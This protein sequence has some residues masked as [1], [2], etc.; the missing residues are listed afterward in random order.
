MLLKKCRTN[1]ILVE[2]LVTIPGRATTAPSPW[3]KWTG[4]AARLYVHGL[5]LKFPAFHDNLITVAC[6]NKGV[7][8]RNCPT[9]PGLVLEG[10]G[11]ETD[12][13]VRC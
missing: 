7:F 12:G 5:G 2:C 13:R 11:I 8:G 10:G 4:G 3:K 9:P 6:T 1:L